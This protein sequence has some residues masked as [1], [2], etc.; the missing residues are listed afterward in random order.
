MKYIILFLSLITSV[1]SGQVNQSVYL[2]YGYTLEVKALT[3]SPVDG[4][5]IYFGNLPKAPVTVAATSKIYVRY[6]C[7]ITFA[8]IYCY[9]GTAGTSESWSLYIRKNNTTDFL[10]ESKAVSTN[11]RTFSNTNMSV[12]LAAGDYIEIKSVNPTWVTNPLTTVFGGY[13]YFASQQ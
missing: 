6:P 13:L 12:S 7:R 5:I 3:S 8:E 11:E 4:Q 2:T 10:I 9:S 1:A